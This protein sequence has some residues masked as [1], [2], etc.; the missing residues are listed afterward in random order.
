MRTKRTFLVV[1]LVILSLVPLM[2][3]GQKEAESKSDELVKLTWHQIGNP[4]ELLPEVMV[5]VNKYLAE[6]IGVELEI[7]VHNWGDYTTKMQ[8][9]HAAGEPFDLAFTAPWANNFIPTASKGAYYPLNDLL[10]E[11]GKDILA[12][13]PAEYWKAATINGKISA[14][15]NLQ[16][17]SNQRGIAVIKKYA[18]KYNFDPTNMTSNDKIFDFF[19]KIKENE[20]DVIPYFGYPEGIYPDLN[21][22][23]P[24]YWDAILG[25]NS[26]YIGVRMNDK[27][28]T[29]INTIKT[30]EYRRNI[31]SNRDMLKANYLPSDFATL[32]LDEEVKG[33]DYAAFVM[34][35]IKPGVEGENL[36]RYGKDTVVFGLF[37]PYVSTDSV[38]STMTAIGINSKHPEKAMELYNLVYSDPYLYNLLVFGVEGVNYTLDENGYVIQNPEKAYGLNAW[39]FGNQFNAYLLPGQD[40]DVWDQTIALDASAELSPILGFVFDPAPV[41]NEIAACSAIFEEYKTTVLYAEDLDKILDE[42]NNALVN[43]GIDKIIAEAQKQIDTWAK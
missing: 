36:V 1:L 32:N 25:E 9:M 39:E 12:K 13:L 37:K 26:D 34:S 29:V 3:N 24:K 28:R 4:Q 6:K 2:A 5:E 15:I 38:Q 40:S 11:Y 16:I 17:M 23:K 30:D 21:D 18:D 14:I 41:R 33:R 22:Q 20:P 31:Q 35:R 27:S 7:T 10:K 19:K 42:Y 8:T 43:S